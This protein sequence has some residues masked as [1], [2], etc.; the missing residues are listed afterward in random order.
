MKVYF[1]LLLLVLCISMFLCLATGCKKAKEGDNSKSAESSQ[2][3]SAE[4]SETSD[5]SDISVPDEEK[6]NAVTFTRLES[7]VIHE[8]DG[9]TKSYTVDWTGEGCSF[10]YYEKYEDDLPVDASL[11]QE[12]GIFSFN[13]NYSEE[14][15]DNYYGRYFPLFIYDENGVIKEAYINKDPNQTSVITYDENGLPSG[16]NIRY[17]YNA[18]KHQAKIPRGGSAGKDETTGETYSSTTYAIY[19][20]NELGNI[21]K[22]D[23]LTVK[24]VNGE[25]IEETTTENTELYEY[26]DAGNLTRFERNGYIVELTYSD[27]M[28]H[29]NWERT[30]PLFYVDWAKASSY[31]FFWNMK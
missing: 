2:D 13:L 7:V 21:I 4:T 5:I 26:D 12:T 15:S 17:E 29:H 18:E 25:I 23:F 6:E 3:V 10:I 19:T 30:I 16:E 28:I 11:D 24:K 9:E 27:E 31:P 8:E 20:F 22:C 1:K 14:N